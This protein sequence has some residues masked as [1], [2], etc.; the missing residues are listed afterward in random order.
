MKAALQKA[1]E[2]KAPAKDPSEKTGNPARLRS[3]QQT[4][5]VKL[6]KNFGPASGVWAAF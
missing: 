5:N 4:G 6:A 1:K 3:P 2:A